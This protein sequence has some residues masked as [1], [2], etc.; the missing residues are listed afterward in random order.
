MMEIFSDP[1]VLLPTITSFAAGIWILKDF[2][3]KRELY[4]KPKVESGIKTIRRSNTGL[5][6]IVW[7]RVRNN[8]SARL[9]FDKAEF[10]VRHL[11]FDSE[12]KII[13]IGGI[14]AVEFPIKA[15]DKTP[16]FPPDWQYSYVDGGGEAEY[17]FTVGITPSPGLYSIN[18]KVFLRENKSDFIQDTTYYNMD[19]L[20]KFEKVYTSD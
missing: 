13:D 3:L 5:V 1:K 15:V 18:T 6:A 12:Y 4:P 11:Q 7:I 14:K 10:F 8:G 16:L 17:R 9:Y 19:S 20:F 2:L